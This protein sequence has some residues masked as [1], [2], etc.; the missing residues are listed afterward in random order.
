MCFGVIR[1]GFIKKAELVL[2][3]DLIRIIKKGNIWMDSL[4]HCMKEDLSMAYE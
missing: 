2:D 1:E 3:P 4:C